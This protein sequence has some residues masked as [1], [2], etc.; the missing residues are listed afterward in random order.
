[1]ITVHHS[2]DAEFGFEFAAGWLQ[3]WLTS[4]P[5]SWLFPRP[6]LMGVGRQYFHYAGRAQLDQTQRRPQFCARPGDDGF[7]QAAVLLAVLF[8]PAAFGCLRYLR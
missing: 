8:L 7:C 3:I 2:R 4:P 1:M 6:S 5:I